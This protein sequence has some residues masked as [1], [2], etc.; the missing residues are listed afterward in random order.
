LTSTNN[1]EITSDASRVF[2]CD[3]TAFFLSPK[4][5]KVLVKRGD[6]TVYSFISNDEKECLTTLVTCNASGQI[7]PPMIVIKEFPKRSLIKYHKTGV[8][9]AAKM[10]G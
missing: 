5:D 4:G 8:L 1:F 9:A 2:N 10:A 7:P 6:K 3:E